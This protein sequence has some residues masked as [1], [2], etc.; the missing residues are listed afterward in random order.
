MTRDMTKDSPVRLIIGF[1]LP[2]LA[3]MLFQQLYNFMDT[4][5]VGRFLGVEALAGVGA[6]GSINFLVLGFCMGVCA[7]FAIPVA[8]CFGAK[9]EAKMHEYEANGVYLAAAFAAV[10]TTVTVLL[11]RNILTIMGTPADC[12]EQAYD[13]IS[14][15]FAGIP[16]MVLYN[17]TSGY[18]RSLGDSRTPLV[19]LVLSSV[20]NIILDLVLI[21][22]FHMGVKG[23]S[24]ATVIS[25]AVSGLL[26]LLWIVL[27]VP[28]LHVRGDQWRVSRRRMQVLCGCGIPMG[29]QYSITAIGSVV[30]Q[31]AVNSLGSLAVAAMTASIKVQNFL[32]CPFDALGSTMATYGAQNVGAGRYDR[33]GKGLISAALIGFAYSVAAFALAVF[34]GDSFVQLFVSD[35]GEELI[36]MAHTFMM[37]Q[38]AFY[39]LLTLVN[40]VRFMIQG[41][42]FSGF[43]VIAG[44][45]EMAARSFTGVFL[46]P[47]F[48]FMGVMMGSPLAWLL[49]DAFLIPA[50]FSC[51]KTLLSKV[52]AVQN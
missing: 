8:Q 24:L 11:C 22:V 20:L 25:Q 44:A 27:K 47:A 32:A 39:P 26:C 19:F 33:L 1:A 52:H 13:Y 23:A 18:L 31:T 37:A 50:Y 42:G 12:F 9:N 51:K 34:L 15:I 48:G 41:M 5:I 46:V 30:L 14:V 17:L 21:L 38:V 40:V 35:G 3:G 29:L 43:A 2:M 28:V 36:R 10:L 45:L 7:G 4:M 49:A 6:T 16:F